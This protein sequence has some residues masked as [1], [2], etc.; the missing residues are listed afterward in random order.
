VL[1]G[2]PFGDIF[3]IVLV[4]AA[5][6]CEKGGF[7]QMIQ[8]GTAKKVI[9]AGT[10]ILGFAA[11]NKAAAAGPCSGFDWALAEQLCSEDDAGGANYCQTSNNMVYFH[12]DNWGP[13]T[14]GTIG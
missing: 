5:V 11:Y 14:Y 4:K 12:C 8:L 10:L 3:R 1:T 13:G 2:V 9:V 7:D 6:V